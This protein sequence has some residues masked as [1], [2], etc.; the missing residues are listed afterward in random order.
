MRFEVGNLQKKKGLGFRA[1]FVLQNEV[2][3]MKTNSS[4][5]Q[6]DRPGPTLP[7]EFGLHL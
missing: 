1:A 5:D 6:K 3:T 4:P 2:M 7:Y